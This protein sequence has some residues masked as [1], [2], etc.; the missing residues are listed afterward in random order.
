MRQPFDEDTS[1]SLGLLSDLIKDFTDLGLEAWTK[2]LNDNENITTDLP[3]NLLFRQ[4]L[5]ASDGIYELVRVGCV[6]ICKPLL[7]TCLECYWQLAFILMD[8]E[9]RK[10]RHF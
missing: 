5:E 10:A 7:R 6:N 8:D 1:K 3:A 9:E 4:I 2:Q